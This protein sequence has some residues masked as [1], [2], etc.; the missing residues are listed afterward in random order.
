MTSWFSQ[1]YSAYSVGQLLSYPDHPVVCHHLAPPFLLTTLS[2]FSFTYSQ[3]KPPF[4]SLGIPR[5]TFILFLEKFLSS[6]CSCLSWHFLRFLALFSW[7]YHLPLILYLY[8][9]CPVKCSY[10][11]AS[12]VSYTITEVHTGGTLVG[13]FDVECNKWDLISASKMLTAL[14]HSHMV[15]WQDTTS[16]R[17][18]K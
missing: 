13:L 11:A 5:V 15:R 16:H 7:P 9:T 17:W 18:S 6:L 3:L 10:S 4:V 1:V 12:T 8:F 2:H 14:K